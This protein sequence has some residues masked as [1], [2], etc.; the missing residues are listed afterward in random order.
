MFSRD[1]IREKRK[2]KGNRESGINQRNFPKGAPAAE[3]VTASSVAIAGCF[4]SE[5]PESFEAPAFKDG[6]VTSI[7]LGKNW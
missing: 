2:E 3:V 6:A 4:A 5:T 7:I 1:S